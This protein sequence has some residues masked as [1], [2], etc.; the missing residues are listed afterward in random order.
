MINGIEGFKKHGFTFDDK[1]TISDVIHLQDDA[2]RQGMTDA[3]E[4]ANNM[5]LINGCMTKPCKAI[6]TKR[7]RRT[8]ILTAVVSMKVSAEPS[9]Y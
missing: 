2:W 8:K 6:L 3:A 5:P 9:N 4:I 7:D 1:I